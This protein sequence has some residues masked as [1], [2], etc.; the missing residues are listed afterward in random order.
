MYRSDVKLRVRDR[1][2]VACSLLAKVLTV[3]YV[4]NY[5]LLSNQSILLLGELRAGRAF[6]CIRPRRD[7]C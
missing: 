1:R 3:V 7:S 6:V 2:L 5:E 4:V